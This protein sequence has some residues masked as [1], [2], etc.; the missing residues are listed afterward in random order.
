MGSHLLNADMAQHFR[1]WWVPLRKRY[2]ADVLEVVHA[3]RCGP[4]RRGRQVSDPIEEARANLESS[5]SVR[6]N[7]RCRH[8]S[9][10]FAESSGRESAV[11]SRSDS[12]PR[13]L[14]KRVRPVS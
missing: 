3:R 14:S 13:G 2:V 1:R 6:L 5:R 4:E 12:P 7:S 8:R 11:R 10:A 9:R